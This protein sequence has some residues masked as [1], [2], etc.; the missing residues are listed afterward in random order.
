[1]VCMQLVILHVRNIFKFLIY[2]SF[3][4]CSA[5]LFMYF[6]LQLLDEKL[7]N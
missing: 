6:F 3:I 2:S 7:N 1:M 4:L 5:F